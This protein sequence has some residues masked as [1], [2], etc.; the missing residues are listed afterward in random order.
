[1]RD[2]GGTFVNNP[3]TALLMFLFGLLY[4]FLG[5]VVAKLLWDKVDRGTVWLGCALSVIGILM[6]Q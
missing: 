1:M 4:V 3:E 6:A 2:L 5:L